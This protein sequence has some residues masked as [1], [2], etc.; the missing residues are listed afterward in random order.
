MDNDLTKR[1]KMVASGSYF[2][3]KVASL[4]ATNVEC[5]ILINIRFYSGSIHRGSECDLLVITPV[6]IYC[7]ECKN[8][9]GFISGE[10]FAPVWSFVSSRKLGHVKNPYLYNQ[11]HIRLIR[12]TFYKNGLNPLDIENVIVVPDSCKIHVA[13]CGVVNLSTLVDR[14]VFECENLKPIYNVKVL[15]D[16][17]N[18]VKF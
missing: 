15:E 17:F 7:I 2:E 10:R 14:I 12:G 8:Y 5:K 13:D 4:I 16:Y 9:K 11:S 3:R 18:K 1:Q 6:K